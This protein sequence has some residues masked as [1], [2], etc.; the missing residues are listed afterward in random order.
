LGGKTNGHGVETALKTC[1]GENIYFDLSYFYN[2]ND[3]T[4]DDATR[5]QRVQA[6]LI[7]KF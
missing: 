1:V 3:L 2:L 5:Y 4:A 6:D 7:L